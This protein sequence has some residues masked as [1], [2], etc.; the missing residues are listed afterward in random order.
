[1]NI[2]IKLLKL[3]RINPL[4]KLILGLIMNIN[5]IVLQYAGGYSNTCGDIGKELGVS[6]QRVLNEVNLLLEM[7]YI[8]SEIGYR[9]RI[10]NVTESF[11]E[12]LKGLTE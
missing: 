11:L 9:S 10:T 7:G 8:T 2:D 1:M 3:K 6:R 5:P 4:Q 12:L